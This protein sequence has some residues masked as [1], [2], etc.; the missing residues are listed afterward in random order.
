MKSWFAELGHLLVSVGY[1][2]ERGLPHV[3]CLWLVH[4]LGSADCAISF[5]L[6]KHCLDSVPCM[7]GFTCCGS[8]YL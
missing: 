2:V 5:T 3:N 8:A 7:S 4:Q 6:C 1:C